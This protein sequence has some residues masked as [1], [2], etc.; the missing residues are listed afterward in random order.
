MK[1]PTI[2][3][4][5]ETQASSTASPNSALR[6]STVGD[7]FTTA[8]GNNANSGTTPADPM[9]S[10]DKLFQAAGL[11]PG[12]AKRLETVRLRLVASPP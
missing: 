11:E 1:M 6:G 5:Q 8:V 4:P 2:V 9:A 12:A 7:Q 10:L 3:S